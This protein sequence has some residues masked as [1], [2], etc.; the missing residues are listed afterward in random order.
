MIRQVTFAATAL[1]ICGACTTPAAPAANA[2][3]PTAESK[4]EM[5][6]PVAMEMEHRA[7]EQKG[8]APRAFD[9]RPPS[10]TRA[11]CAVTDELFTVSSETPVSVYQ[12]RT[13][14]FCCA[15]C[16]PRFDAAPEKYAR[17]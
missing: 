6:V 16:K 15:S 9:Q 12:G 1:L 4:H 8:D 3:P 11:R 17:R 13:Y 10:G 14:V 5:A 7:V 2:A